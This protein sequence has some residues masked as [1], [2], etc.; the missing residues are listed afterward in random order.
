MVTP[1]AALKELA[2]V[3]S[4]VLGEKSNIKVVGTD[5]GTPTASPSKALLL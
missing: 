5:S 1:H 4:G 2:Y 3:H